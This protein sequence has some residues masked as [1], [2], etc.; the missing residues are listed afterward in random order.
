MTTHP[1]VAEHVLFTPPSGEGSKG[2]SYTRVV[3]LQHP[4]PAQG[5]LLASF[6]YF[7]S[8]ALPIY[9]SLDDGRTWSP[10]PIA[11]VRDT[12]RP[13]WGLRY[14]PHLY[15]LP[16]DAGDL[17][18]GTLLL[19]GNSFPDDLSAF[20]LQL[21][22]SFDAGRSWT[23]RSALA[24][25]PAADAPVWEPNLLLLPGGELVAYYADET[26]K[27]EGFNQLI[28]HK[29]SRDGGLTWEAQVYDIAHPTFT[30][31]PGMPVVVPLP[32]GT[33]VMGYEALIVQDDGSTYAPMR[34]KFSNDGLNWDD[35]AEPGLPVH[36][37]DGL[38]LDSTPYLGWSPAGGP[39]GTLI[40]TA[41]HTYDHAGTKRPHVLMINRDDGRG[42]WEALPSPVQFRPGGHLQAGW[43][44]AVLASPEGRHVLHLAS[45]DLGNGVNEIRYATA[46]LPDP[47]QAVL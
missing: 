6:E 15:E 34:V 33:Y 31:R 10:E 23:F 3:R 21:Y 11:V 38:W 9:E 4:G 26:H 37:A 2:T 42:P 18:A 29:V 12:Q 24:N 28:G 32:D 35:P 13:E 47:A 27:A 16:A 30:Q 20:E 41:M 1:T 7:P 40:A 44:Q 36:T 25:G 22:V 39:N 17:P 14:Q 43:S 45:S 5:R 46:P 19:A 8:R